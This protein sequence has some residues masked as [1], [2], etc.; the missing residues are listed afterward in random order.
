MAA[1]EAEM[2]EEE[3]EAAA[4]LSTP[5][6]SGFFCSELVANCY[7]ALGL[8]PA[9]RP[10]SGYWPVSFSEGSSLPSLPLVEGAALGDEIP[11]KWS[12]PAVASLGR[13]L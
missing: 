1:E 6:P 11:I 5:P 9:E 12:T 8:L 4:N 2:E 10:A 7:M 3:E 13:A